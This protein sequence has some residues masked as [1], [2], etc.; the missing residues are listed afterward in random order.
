MTC[1]TDKLTSS[2][3]RCRWQWS[4]TSTVYG[5][6][7]E[8]FHAHVGGLMVDCPSEVYGPLTLSD[9]EELI[10]TLTEELRAGTGRVS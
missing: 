3:P 4:I 9:L 10:V 2:A 8:A 1:A 7:L 5:Y 6:R